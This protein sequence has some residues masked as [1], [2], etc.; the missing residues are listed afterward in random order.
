M[1]S[2]AAGRSCIGSRARIEVIDV[3]RGFTLL[4][5]LWAHIVDQYYAGERPAQV[6]GCRPISRSCEERSGW[7]GGL[8]SDALDARL[9]PSAPCGF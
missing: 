4:G 1:V 7:R 5:V 3:L 2:R 9:R 8:F 6:A